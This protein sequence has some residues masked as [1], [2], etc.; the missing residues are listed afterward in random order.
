MAGKDKF[1]DVV[2]Y[3]KEFTFPGDDDP[4][5]VYVALENVEVTVY[6]READGDREGS[7]ATIYSSRSGIGKANP[8]VTDTSGS[9]SFF[10]DPGEYEIDYLDLNDP[11]RTGAQT[12]HWSSVP[13]GFDGLIESQLPG[14][15]GGLAKA[16]DI[17]VTGASAVGAADPVGWLWCDGRVFEQATYPDLFDEIDVAFNIGGETG[18]QFRIPDLRG[19]VPSGANNMGTA[20]GS[21]G[22]ITTNGA[23]GQA[24]GDDEVTL[25]EDQIPEHQHKNDFEMLRAD[26]G[27]HFAYVLSGPGDPGDVQ[28]RVNHNLGYFTQENDSDELAHNNMQPYQCVCYLIK[29]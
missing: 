6:K 3:T 10:A 11:I 21:S 14:G 28:I 5:R 20:A 22:R 13:G 23:K 17:K 26:G 2:G 27:D 9:V 1:I 15:G 16:G 7:P 12:I 29:I 8:W 18:S 4:S 25:N 24:S 19:R